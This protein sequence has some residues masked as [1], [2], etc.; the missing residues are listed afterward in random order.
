MQTPKSGLKDQIS[1]KLWNGL[2]EGQRKFLLQSERKRQCI[3]TVDDD[4]HA[5]PILKDITKIQM[6]HTASTGTR[7][8]IDQ[9]TFCIK[10]LSFCL[11]MVKLETSLA[12]AVCCPISGQ[13]VFL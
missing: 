8:N 5:T 6:Q 11:V 2:P 4:I 3:T 7:K 10:L 9:Y 13:T 1:E 12:W